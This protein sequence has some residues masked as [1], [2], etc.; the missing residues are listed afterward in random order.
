LRGALIGLRVRTVELDT[1]PAAIIRLRNFTATP[2]ELCRLLWL[3]L[4]NS[5]RSVLPAA[6]DYRNAAIPLSPRQF[7]A[8]VL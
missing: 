4:S 5:I 6:V 1:A 8:C 3:P 7:V 2:R